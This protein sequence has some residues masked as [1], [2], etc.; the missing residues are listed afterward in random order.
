MTALAGAAPTDPPPPRRRWVHRLLIVVVALML[1][2]L[3]VGALAHLATGRFPLLPV[4]AAFLVLS[5][6]RLVAIAVD[7]VQVARARAARGESDRVANGW[8]WAAYKLVAALV[9]FAGAAYLL[10][11][12]GAE[13]LERIFGSEG[14][15]GSA[16]A[17]AA[18]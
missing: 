14:A 16:T 12:P 3:V 2:D 11:A 7:T 4:L 8:G 9:A 5:G 15:S 17:P 10:F 1:V 6:I 18:P 13:R